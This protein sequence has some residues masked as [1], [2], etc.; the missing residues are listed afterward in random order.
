[1]TQLCQGRTP[2]CTSV[3]LEWTG[4]GCGTWAHAIPIA[5]MGTTQ[6]QPYWEVCGSPFYPVSQQQES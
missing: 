4:L 5:H 6:W 3:V 1:M 2:S